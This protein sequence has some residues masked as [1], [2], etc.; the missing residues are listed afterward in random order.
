MEEK[1]LGI[2]QLP[3]KIGGNSVLYIEGEVDV[4]QQFN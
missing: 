4:A 1:T 3:S 2:L